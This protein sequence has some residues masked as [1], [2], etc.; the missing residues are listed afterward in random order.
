MTLWL[1]FSILKPMI[2]LIKDVYVHVYFYFYICMDSAC[3]SINQKTS[4]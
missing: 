2:S 4:K 1:Y 3:I